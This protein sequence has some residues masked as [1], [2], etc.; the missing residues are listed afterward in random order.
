M[1]RAGYITEYDK[2]VGTHLAAILTGGD[3]LGTRKVSRQH[4]LDLEREA[5]LTLCG[6]PKTQERM[7]HMLR[8]GKPLRN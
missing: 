2:V 1:E 3:F 4:L 5:F 7:E 8:Q 6:Q